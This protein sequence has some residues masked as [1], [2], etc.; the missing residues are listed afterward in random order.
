[1]P[2][3]SRTTPITNGYNLAILTNI[4]PKTTDPTPIIKNRDTVI[5]SVIAFAFDMCK[6][7]I[8][9]SASAFTNNAIQDVM[10]AAI[11]HSTLPFN[12]CTRY[13]DYPYTLTIATT[14]KI[15]TSTSACLHSL[16]RSISVV[17]Y[18]RTCHDMPK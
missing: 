3:R 10:M 16:I 9:S 13:N 4:F 5:S 14:V 15:C 17:C 7:D 1:M 2:V 8:S 6:I 11:W 18:Y 12:D